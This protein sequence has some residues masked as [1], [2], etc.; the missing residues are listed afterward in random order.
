MVR[1]EGRDSLHD[2]LP[3]RESRYELPVYVVQAIAKVFE[4]LGQGCFEWRA[5]SGQQKSPT[6][7]AGGLH[8]IGAV[9]DHASGAAGIAVGSKKEEP[10]G[11]E[12]HG[13]SVDR[14][15]KAKHSARIDEKS[16][17]RPGPSVCELR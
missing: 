7:Q 3:I 8:R 15:W 9:Q 11:G 14:G 2:L 16:I 12:T 4:V 13:L 5:C 17:P 1:L 6:A 10:V